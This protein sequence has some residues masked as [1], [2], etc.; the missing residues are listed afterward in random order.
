M[1]AVIF[2]GSH[3]FSSRVFAFTVLTIAIFT[4]STG[5]FLFNTDFISQ[6]F[7]IKLV[8]FLGILSTTSL[9]YFIESFRR[10]GPAGKGLTSVLVIALII[11]FYFTFYTSLI[12]G[13]PI[14]N[15]LSTVGIIWGWTYG[16]Y[17]PIFYAFS[18]IC[19]IASVVK[20]IRTHHEK[21][22]KNEKHHVTMMLLGFLIGI[23]SILIFNSILPGMKIFDYAWVGPSSGIIWVSIIGY[24]M[25]RYHQMNV[26]VIT[27][28]ILMVC[29]MVLSFINIFVGEI[30]GFNDRILIFIVFVALG[31]WIIRGA[32]R[33][34]EQRAL[35]KDMNVNL[36]KKVVD[37]TKEIRRSYEIERGAHLEL[38]K[39]DE[40]KNQFIMITQH[41]LRTPITSIK[42][43]LES[44][45]NDTYG[46]LSPEVKKA[47]SDMGESVERLN[48]LINSLLSISALKSGIETLEKSSVNM[49]KIID[50]TIV[51]LHKE[52]ERKRVT[53][54]VSEDH[55]PWPILTIDQKRMQEVIFII[56]ENAVKYNV[57]KGNVMISGQANEKTFNL[58][59]E[60]TGQ[61]LSSEDKKKIFTELFYRSSQAQVAHPTGMGIGLSMAQAIV[62]A[63]R[64]TI[65]IASRKQGGGVIL[66]LSLPY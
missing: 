54:I 48:H 61:E 66:T 1:S 41:H 55:Q 43:Q 38:E 30:L 35:L 4:A 25:V 20:L 31:A 5:Y 50:D 46:P 60:N 36:E 65:S 10:D 9:L 49:R 52:I 22:N 44:L 27:T 56:I 18:V 24:S 63:H 53:V 16:G 57:E 45:M 51:E 29:M 13:Y 64:G 23:I 21:T 33:E 34:A 47:M 14:S 2:F 40:A 8:F 32:L 39:I 12:T 37:Q 17:S 7:G 42:W 58:T 59:V 62:E 11:I 26:R 28:E 3:K 15:K 19:Y 6:V